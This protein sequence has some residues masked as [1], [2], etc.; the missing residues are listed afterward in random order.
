MEA[1]T[2]M[3]HDKRNPSP[4]FQFTFGIRLISCSKLPMWP[5]A[6]RITQ[7]GIDTSGQ[8]TAATI[9]SGGKTYLADIVHHCTQKPITQPTAYIKQTAYSRHNRKS[10]NLWLHNI[11]V[12][13]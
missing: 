9:L 6:G 7:L 3:G 8:T 4:Q 12:N 13:E 11:N 10:T 5:W 2:L 1:N